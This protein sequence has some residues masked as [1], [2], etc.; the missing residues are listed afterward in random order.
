M[1][2]QVARGGGGDA[3]TFKGAGI[4]RGH[5]SQCVC[6]CVGGGQSVGA[7]FRAKLCCI[8]NYS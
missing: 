7:L 3:P 5:F 6:V 8:N 4:F 2:E 1:S